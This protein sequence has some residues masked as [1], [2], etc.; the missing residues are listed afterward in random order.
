M[1]FL[2]N[3]L[4]IIGQYDNK[5]SA[6]EKMEI[7]KDIILNIIKNFYQ[8]DREFLNPINHF[9]IHSSFFNCKLCSDFTISDWLKEQYRDRTKI[10]VILS[11][12][13]RNRDLYIDNILNKKLHYWEC[14]VNN[15]DYCES[16]LA[17]AV[18]LKGVLIS[19]QNAPDFES[20]YIEVYFA[21][22]EQ[23]IEKKNISNLINVRQARKLRPRYKFHPKHHPENPWNEAS[24]I[25]LNDK[26]AQAVLDQAVIHNLTDGKQYYG[27]YKNNYYE[28]QPGGEGEGTGKFDAE[29]YPVYH[30][31]KINENELIIKVDNEI[32]GKLYS[33]QNDKK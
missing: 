14:K 22:E 23:I 2:I 4:S 12:I 5:Y 8:N 6:K 26:E 28:F 9:K 17:G 10:S 7:I 29:G 21:I 13:K 20:E 16:S 19:L 15:Q 27:Y 33:L 11:G 3:E 30:G 32:L 1:E 24:P 18:Y 31:Y 25:D